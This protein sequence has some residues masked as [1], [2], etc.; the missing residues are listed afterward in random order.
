MTGASEGSGAEKGPESEPDAL[1]RLYDLDLEDNPGDVELFLALAGRTGDP[2][3][4]LAV[5]SGRIA[6]PLAEA[7]FEVVAVDRDP[8]MLRRAKARALAAGR[9]VA[10]RLR[11]VEA[12]ALDV[13]LAEAGT[14]RLAFIALNSLLVLGDRSAQA[15]AF[16]TLA[17]HLAPDGLAVVDVWLPDADQLS[18]YDGRL[19]VEYV[20]AAR[21]GGPLVTKTAAARHHSGGGIELTAIYEESHQGGPVR[22]WVRRDRLQLVGP[23]ELVALAKAAGMR[24]ETLAGDY[25]LRPYEP[26]ADRAIVLASPGEA[27]IGAARARARRSNLDAAGHVRR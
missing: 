23:E 11:L 19:S 12:D 5:G 21:D 9:A 8:A 16:G 4:E 27:A 6:V 20:R 14:F 17:R 18:R 1:A 26:G 7:G 15:R 24:V 13:R 22:R 3:L 10:R 25:D 2:I